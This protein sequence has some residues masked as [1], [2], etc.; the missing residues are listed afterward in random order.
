MNKQTSKFI[1]WNSTQQQKEQTIARC[2]NMDE[3]PQ[4]GELNKL[5]DSIVKKVQN[6]QN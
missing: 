3:S 1:Q 6:G 4:H 5:Y 2:N